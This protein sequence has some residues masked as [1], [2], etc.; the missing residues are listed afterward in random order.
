MHRKDYV[1]ALENE[2][3]K[4]IALFAIQIV[5]VSIAFVSVLH[6]RLAPSTNITPGL[7]MTLMLWAVGVAAILTVCLIVL[8]PG[9]GSSLWS[10]AFSKWNP[11]GFLTL[12][13]FDLA[14]SLCALV[15]IL[16]L[17][18]LIYATGGSRQTM[19][20]PYLFTIVLLIM[21]LRAPLGTIITCF[22][23][24]VIIFWGC[25]FY[26][27]ENFEVTI[28]RTYDIYFGTITSLCVLFP[29]L[30]KIFNI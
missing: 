26:H 4:W 5:G 19:Y 28:K 6:L 25:L 7:L 30:V 17:S 10:M 2:N 27:N 15:D 20:V 11:P 23:L 1:M 22:A 29:T 8:T 13:N 9:I 21:M 24:T 16:G 18:V 12:L 3:A 14:I